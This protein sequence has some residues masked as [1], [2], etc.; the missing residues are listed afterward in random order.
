MQQEWLVWDLISGRFRFLL[1][2]LLES[3]ESPTQGSPLMRV[4]PWT[5]ATVSQYEQIVLQNSWI[6]FQDEGTMR[7]S[8]K[9]P[10]LSS[11][12]QL[13]CSLNEWL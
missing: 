8:P 6:P 13:S 1:G 11:S 7:L 3:V 4:K 10:L 5:H 9:E 12:P 2:Y